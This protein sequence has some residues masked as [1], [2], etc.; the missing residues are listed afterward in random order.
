MF[1][2]VSFL[3]TFALNKLIQTEESFGFSNF[4]DLDID[5]DKSRDIDLS[6]F[7]SSQG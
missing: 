5:K 3:F 4:T 2:I 7:I 6:F 1:N